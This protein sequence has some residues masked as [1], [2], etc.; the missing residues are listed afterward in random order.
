MKALSAVVEVRSYSR[1]SRTISCD[2]VTNRFGIGG[3]Q[4]FA[5]APL[6]RRDWHRRAGS[7]PR[8]PRCSAPRSFAPAP[9]LRSSSSGFSTS[10]PAFIRSGDLEGQFARNERLRAVEE[11]IERLDPVAAADGVGVAKAARGDQRGAR[12][13]ALQ[14]RVDGDGR[15]VQQFRQR[16]HLAMGEG[17]AVRHAARRVGGHGRG[18]RGDDTAVDAADQVGEGPADVDADNVHA[19]RTD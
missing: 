17:E 18:L 8:P 10:P 5:D 11:Q 7:T 16:G 19:Y 13:L 15:A 4:D 1:Y 6:V 14:H 12:A 9:A 2:S 3:A